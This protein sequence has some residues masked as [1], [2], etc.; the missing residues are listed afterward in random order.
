LRLYGHGDPT[1]NLEQVS[2]RCRAIG[3][4]RAPDVAK[5][6]APAKGPA[7]R[8]RLVYFH[9]VGGAVDTRIYERENL[10][11]GQKLLG[12]AIID[13]WTMTTVVPP[14][15]SC[16]CDDYGNLILEPSGR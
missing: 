4:V 6:S 2:I 13:E 12:P 11:P 15:W 16:L 8:A 7:P 10:A 5:I 14:G 1:A 9:N 3:R